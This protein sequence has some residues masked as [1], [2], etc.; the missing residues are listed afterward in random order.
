MQNVFIL[1]ALIPQNHLTYTRRTLSVLLTNFLLILLEGNTLLSILGAQN[2]LVNTFIPFRR[3]R[4]K[5]IRRQKMNQISKLWRVCQRRS[6]NELIDKVLYN[7]SAYFELKIEVRR[8]NNRITTSD[9]LSFRFILYAFLGRIFSVEVVTSNRTVRKNSIANHWSCGSCVRSYLLI[10]DCICNQNR[11]NRTISRVFFGI[12][13][14]NQKIYKREGFSSTY[15]LWGSF[16]VRPFIR[17]FGH[18]L[19]H[20]IDHIIAV[21]SCYIFSHVFQTTLSWPDYQFRF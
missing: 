21:E 13:S 1:L 10:C 2:C 6:K 11:L 7:W 4:T 8:N 18:S 3:I 20:I 9:K 14:E 12:V 5:T 16:Q 19:T 17:I 15:L